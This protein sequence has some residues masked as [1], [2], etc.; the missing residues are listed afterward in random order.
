MNTEG[1][2]ILDGAGIKRALTRI[3]HEILEHNKGMKELVLVGI[4]T[5]GVYLASE[6][7]SR[8]NEIEGG[9]VP[10]GSVDITLYRDDIKGHVETSSGWQDRY[11]LFRR[12][13][14]SGAG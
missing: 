3:A 6:L 5:G 14:K 10:V 8:L 13:E 12:G 4:R 9:G 11:T 1:T 2:I 7:A